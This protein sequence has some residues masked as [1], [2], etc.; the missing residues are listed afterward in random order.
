MRLCIPIALLTSQCVLAIVYRP[1]AT[2]LTSGFQHFLIVGPAQGR[3]RVRV[4]Y[5]I[6]RAQELGDGKPEGVGEFFAV[7]KVRRRI[8]NPSACGEMPLGCDVVDGDVTFKDALQ[9]RSNVA[10]GQEPEATG[11]MPRM[12]EA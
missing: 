1:H 8:G 10:R 2:L 11:L 12:Q 6:R 9:G 7:N 4:Q 3:K 5:A